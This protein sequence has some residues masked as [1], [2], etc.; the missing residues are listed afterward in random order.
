MHRT[1]LS[2][3]Q[4]VRNDVFDA[5]SSSWIGRKHNLSPLLIGLHHGKPHFQQHHDL[6]SQRLPDGGNRLGMMFLIHYGQVGSV[7][8]SAWRRGWEASIRQ[9]PF[10]AASWRLT[11]EAPRW[12]Q[13][14]QHDHFDSL[15]SSWIGRKLCLPPWL[16]S[17]HDGKP[18]QYQLYDYPSERPLMMTTDSGCD[19]SDNAAMADRKYPS[20]FTCNYRHDDNLVVLN[21]PRSSIVISTI[22]QLN[23]HLYS[24]TTQLECTQSI[25][26][27]FSSSARV[28]SLE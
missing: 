13:S 19:S 20:P 27:Q 1:D 21:L 17:L 10:P 5:L 9:T 24:T 28:V 26:L 23:R 25:A 11:A 4:S 12:G 16:I 15:S 6:S 14:T 2:M 22:L 3:G 7:A 8:S 18:H